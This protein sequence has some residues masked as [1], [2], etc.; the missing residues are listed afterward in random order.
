MT[1]TDLGN[2][3]A[4]RTAYSPSKLAA[5]YLIHEYARR[6]PTRST[7][8]GYNPGFAPGTDLAR[9]A[10]PASRLAMKWIMP[11]LT[12]TPSATT[13]NKTGGFLADAAF[14]TIEAPNGIYIGRDQLS[15]SSPEPYDSLRERKTW[16]AVETL[17]TGFFPPTVIKDT[18]RSID[19]H[20]HHHGS[21]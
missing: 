6:F 10:D 19:A 15:R 8:A 2:T 3:P 13:L 1:D 5:I 17:T 11:L 21:Q 14:G 4:G 7:L 16:E 12:I 9:D 20:N 18:K